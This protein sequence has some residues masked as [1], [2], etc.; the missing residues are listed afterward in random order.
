MRGLLVFVAELLVNNAAAS[1]SRAFPRCPLLPVLRCVLR[2]RR[3]WLP[4]DPA[5]QLGQKTAP[6]LPFIQ[7]GVEI[8]VM[9]A[10]HIEDV[11]DMVRI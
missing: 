1:R 8:L 6:S 7:Q 5:F 10:V 4:A 3:R 2:V 11:L 9:G